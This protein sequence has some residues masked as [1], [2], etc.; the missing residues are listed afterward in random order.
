[1]EEKD[2]PAKENPPFAGGLGSEKEGV[3]TALMVGFAAFTGADGAVAAAA[4]AVKENADV[5]VVVERG[6]VVVDEPPSLFSSAF[7]RKPSYF[8]CTAFS[9]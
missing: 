6:A 3:E 4:G 1:L 5:D 2:D 8:A 7:W 9:T